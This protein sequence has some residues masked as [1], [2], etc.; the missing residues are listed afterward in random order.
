[1]LQGRT[2]SYSDTQRYR[3][4]PN[5]LQLPIN[6]PQRDAAAVTNQRDGQMTYVVDGRGENK[7]VNYEPSAMGGLKEAPKPAKDYHQ[8]VEGHLGRYQTTRT[9]DDYKQAGDRYRTFADWERD[10]LIANLSADM[11]ECPEPIALRMVWHFF[12]CDPDYGRRVAEGAGIDLA[13]AKALPPL[14]GKPAP[15]AHR[16]GPTYTDGRLEEVPDETTSPRQEAA[17]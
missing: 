1:M 17:E 7:H 10:D 16:S 12:H 15:G 9:A 14:D 5:Y 6:A 8:W 4:G 3:V 2:L 13:K 11:R